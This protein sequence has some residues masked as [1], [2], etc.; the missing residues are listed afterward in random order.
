MYGTQS[1]TTNHTT[2]NTAGVC[3]C[4]CRWPHR[5]SLVRARCLVPGYRVLHLGIVVLAG[6]DEAPDEGAQVQAVHPQRLWPLGGGGRCVRA[7]DGE[8]HVC[9]HERVLDAV[10]HGYRPPG[11]PLHHLPQAVTPPRL[12]DFQPLPF[13]LNCAVYIACNSSPWVPRGI[14][15]A[16]IWSAEG[17]ATS[18][19]VAMLSGALSPIA[20]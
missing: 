7:H 19:T 11:A 3:W 5:T 12:Y 13:C 16:Q 8:Q 17:C 9:V 10:P 18:R 2:A 14:E 6:A 1:T 15:A 4:L 20:M